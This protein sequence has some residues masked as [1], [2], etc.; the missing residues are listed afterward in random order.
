MSNNNHFMHTLNSEWAATAVSRS[1][2]RRLKAWAES[3]DRFVGCESLDEI[4]AAIIGPDEDRSRQLSWALLA[5][6]NEDELAARTMLRVLRPALMNELV[7]VVVPARQS[8]STSFSSD[9]CEAEQ[10]LVTSA[11]VAIAENAGSTSMWPISDLVHRSHR[12]VVRAIRAD[13]A[14]NSQNVIGDEDFDDRWAA[15]ESPVPGPGDQSGGGLG[16]LVAV[17]E[18]IRSMN[19]ISDEEERLILDTRVAGFRIDELSA[20]TGVDHWALYKRRGRA[21]KRMLAAHAQLESDAVAA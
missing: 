5:I 3:D 9:D 7:R 8:N 19:V 18:A 21:E 6:V 11:V 15:E 2:S 1:S 13:R 17:V 10:V 20:A 4:V 12:L 14:W 16:D